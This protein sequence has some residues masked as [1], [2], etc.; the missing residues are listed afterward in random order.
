ML[1]RGLVG[2][3]IGI[4]LGAG[5]GALT[6]GW[7]GSLAVGSSW[8]GPTR[9]F[10][11][12]AAYSG[13]VAGAVFGVSL[14]LYIIFA[15]IGIRWAAVAGGVVGMI[16]VM[17]LWFMRSDVDEQLRSTFARI[18][19]LVLSLVIWVLLGLLLSAVA[20]KLRKVG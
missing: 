9:N 8:I 20:T 7:D 5:A 12:L 4:L 10:W 19:P 18:G 11:P 15:G 3:A 13:A 14:G 1:I 2:A 17:A 6:F 16:G